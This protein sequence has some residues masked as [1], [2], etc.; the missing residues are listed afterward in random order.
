MD[1]VLVVGR[2]TSQQEAVSFVAGQRIGASVD[3]SYLVVVVERGLA[4]V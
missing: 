1:V 2:K 3:K 4:V